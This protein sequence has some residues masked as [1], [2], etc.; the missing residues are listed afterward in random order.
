MADHTITLTNRESTVLQKVAKKNSM[1]TEEYISF[2]VRQF[3]KEQVRGHYQAIFNEMS[4]QELVSTFGDI[5]G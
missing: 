3:L 4:E 5:G 2:F 1:S